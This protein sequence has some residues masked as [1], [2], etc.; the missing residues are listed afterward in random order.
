[1]EKTSIVKIYWNQRKSLG[2]YKKA[3]FRRR[4]SQILVE[5]H[6]A[7]RQSA[8]DIMCPGDNMRWDNMP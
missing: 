7:P 3:E 2:K 1:M 5:G 4:P 8:P 6:G